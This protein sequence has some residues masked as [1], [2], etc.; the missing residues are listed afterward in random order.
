MPS[1]FGGNDSKIFSD[2]LIAINLKPKRHI[3]YARGILYE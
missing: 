1:V 3:R 2:V